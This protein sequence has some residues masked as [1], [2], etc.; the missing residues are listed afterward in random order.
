MLDGRGDWVALAV[1]CLCNLSSH[2][3]ASIS[4]YS[5][6]AVSYRLSASLISR[7]AIS[8]YRAYSLVT[9]CGIKCACWLA[10][11]TVANLGLGS[12]LFLLP[13]SVSPFLPFA[14]SP[15]NR[16]SRSALTSSFSNHKYSSRKASGLSRPLSYEVSFLTSGMDLSWSEMRL[17]TEWEL[18]PSERRAWKTSSCS[19]AVYAVV[20]MCAAAGATGVLLLLQTER[21]RVGATAEACHAVRSRHAAKLI[22]AACL[23][24]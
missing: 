12:F 1:R 15:S 13:G 11:C 24:G 20:V 16:S 10:S 7:T 9:N 4:R 14:S 18:T 6:V 3:P 23:R 21:A 19:S 5:R 8:R 22:I 17:K 2:L